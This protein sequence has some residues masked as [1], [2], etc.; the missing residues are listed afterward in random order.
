[1]GGAGE[2]INTLCWM[3]YILVGSQIGGVWLDMALNVFN[4]HFHIWFIVKFGYSSFE[5]LLFWLNHQIEK[6]SK[7][8]TLWHTNYIPYI[9]CFSTLKHM[10][11]S[12]IY[13]GLR[14]WTYKS[15]YLYLWRRRIFVPFQQWQIWLNKIVTK[16]CKD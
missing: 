8:W 7:I 12:S 5:W 10:F 2:I 11:T 4:F 16:T 13:H 6:K 3:W 1:M 9:L 14:H 15:T